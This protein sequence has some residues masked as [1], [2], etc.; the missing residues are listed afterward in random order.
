MNNFK[1]G[2]LARSLPLP[3]SGVAEPFDKF[4]D[5]PDQLTLDFK[6]IPTS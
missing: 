6:R 2:P 5:L 3:Q 4:L 1:N